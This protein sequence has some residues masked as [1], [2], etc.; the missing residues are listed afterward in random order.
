[1]I[2]KLILIIKRNNSTFI[3]KR[4]NINSNVGYEDEHKNNSTDKSGQGGVLLS[5]VYMD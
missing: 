5:L 4:K 3:N 2:V 1:M